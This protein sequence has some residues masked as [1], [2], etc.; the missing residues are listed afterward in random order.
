[1]YDRELLA[2]YA[3]IKQ[4]RFMLERRRFY[5]IT[6]HKPLTFAFAQKLDHASVRQCCQ[7]AFISE[8]T[9][10][11]IYVPREDNPVT[12]ALSRVDSIIMPVIVTEE[13]A[14]QQTTD[15]EFRRVQS[16]LSN[17]KLQKFLL[18]KTN[19]TLHCNCS[20]NNVRPF[21]SVILRRRVYDMIHG[22][23][24]PSGKTIRQQI[25][26]EICLDEHEQG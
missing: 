23:S 24:H 2:I 26:T 18:P 13:L 16:S 9:T 19:S 17:L 1:V 20:Q 15:Q 25:N 8:F 21:V 12:D 3:T 4:F 10:D 5:V 7:L 11:I 6:D 14:Q 22:M